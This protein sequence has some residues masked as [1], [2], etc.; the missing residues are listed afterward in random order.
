MPKESPFFVGGTY[1]DRKRG[2]V[3]T[4]L[5]GNGM[6]IEYDDGEVQTL[7]AN[8]MAMK[9]R[10]YNNIMAEYRRNHP[11]ASE[12][13]F[14]TL[15]FLAA[16]SRFDAELPPQSTANFLSQYQ[17]LTGE[18]ASSGHPGIAMLAS[19]SDKWGSELR[20]YFPTP[21]FELDFGTPVQVRSGQEPGI[22]RVNNNRLWTKLV[23][24]GF[25]LGTDHD[26]ARIRA[27]VPPGM[28]GAF[29]RGY[30]R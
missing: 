22:F 4:E 28:Q 26:V 12:P 24:L 2:Y 13:Y 27:T 15:G 14:E 18:R 21:P 11:S 25:R 10:I 6:T 8:S 7:N 3:V 17:A 16:H 1:R 20:V 5:N 9:A 23:A 29:D 19:G 30:S